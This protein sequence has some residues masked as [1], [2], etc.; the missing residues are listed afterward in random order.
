[1]QK[2]TEKRKTTKVAEAYLAFLY[3]PEG[4]EIIANHNFRPRDANVL[5]KHAAKYPTIRTF[6]V[7]QKLGGWAAVQKAHFA[8]GA[9]YDQIILKR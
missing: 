4:Q 6:T 5:R 2:V 7:E 9:T 3:S 1:V 8:D